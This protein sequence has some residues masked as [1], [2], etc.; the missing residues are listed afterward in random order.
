M[1]S[2]TT[3]TALCAGFA[4]GLL[5]ASGASAQQELA[6]ITAS[7]GASGDEFANAVG[8]S[9][10]TAVFGAG[11]KDAG[12]GFFS[13][14]AYVFRNV[15]GTWQELARVTASDGQAVD[16]FGSSVAI[17]GDTV[18][19]ASNNPA[20]GSNSGAV[21]IYREQGG[22]WQE[23]TKIIG[24]DT[25]SGDRFGTSIAMDDDLAVIGARAHGT[26]G[27]AAYIWRE[28]GG[29]WQEIGK[30]WNFDG[31]SGDEFG[32][33]VAIDNETVV[34]GAPFDDFAGDDAG[35]VYVF[36]SV[37]GLWQQ[38]ARLTASDAGAGDRLGGSVSISGDAIIVGADFQDDAS[39]AA[40]IFREDNG[41]WTQEAKLTAD[42]PTPFSLFGRRVSIDGDHAVVA[43][44]S[45]DGGTV[46]HFQKVN[47][48]WELQSGFR[49][50]DAGAGDR[51]GLGLALQGTTALV[52][53]PLH[54]QPA[55]NAGA[56]YVVDLEGGT[57]PACPPDLNG[58]G[59]V[60]ADDFFLFLQLFADGD[61]RADFNNDGV[62]DADDF[63]DF[64][65]AFAAGC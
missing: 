58:D 12:N 39:G 10:D 57:G 44:S 48:T 38:V 5:G 35:A 20:A 9:G 62:I 4:L 45:L 7:D 23:V 42:V 31:T 50:S 24:Q 25:V 16:V 64:L 21:Y 41:S 51:F 8:F 37:A 49:N 34:V 29:N 59:V 14:A 47:G 56:A 17:A 11:G 40:Y 30:V 15:G 43:A 22:N 13:G 55:N 53:A 27:G 65:T 19:V 28:T 61:M 3:R 32:S 46:F 54:N 52:G 36:R 6:K 2:R 1:I 63:F 33:S 18:M 60:D 26:T